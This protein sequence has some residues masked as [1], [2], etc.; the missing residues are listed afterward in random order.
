MINIKKNNGSL[1][2]KK[3]LLVISE[4]LSGGVSTL[5]TSTLSSVDPSAGTIISRSTA[6]IISIA[7][8]ITNDL[9]SKLRIRYTI[10]GD[11]FNV[12]TLRYGNTL[13]KSM[14]DKKIDDKE[15]EDLK[16]VCNQ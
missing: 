7:V 1:N 16:N 9:I 2:T 12:R 11:C 13:R 3:V 6:L 14:V 5:T 8:L 10:L 15:A 4:V